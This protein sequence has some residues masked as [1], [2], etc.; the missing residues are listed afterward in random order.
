MSM[1][2]ELGLVGQQPNTALAVFFIPYIVFEI[3]SNIL[4]KK[5]TPHVWLTLCM[6]GFGIVMLGQGFVQNYNG[7]L[8]TRIL[9][10]LFEAGVFPGS[11]YLISFWYKREESQK[12]FAI[13]F[14]SAVLAS[15]FG[16]LLATAIANMDGVGGKSNWRWIFILEGI[17]SCLVAFAAFFLVSDFPSEAKW[18]SER[19]KQFVLKRTH[20]E[21]TTSAGQVNG[22]DIFE[23]F[24]DPKNYLGALMYLSVVEP[25]YAFA[26]FTPTII[27]TLGYSTVQT[28]LHS[29]PP[30]AAALGMC[31]LLGYLSDRSKYRLPYVLFPGALLIAGLAILMTTHGHYSAQYAGLCLV[32][33]G[34]FGGGPTVICWYLMNLRGHQQRS[35]GSAFMISIGNTGGI[36]APFTFLSKDSPYYRTGYSVCM[37]IVVLGIVVSVCYELLV[38]RERRKFRLGGDRADHAHDLSL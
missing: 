19:E 3:P 8:A 26:Y 33:M 13:Y 4:L 1:P 14:C 38:L 17:F 22:R 2:E 20:T 27:K 9:L 5:F 7:L 10:G 24:K 6:L 25:I 37:G 12:R 29:V 18:L 21:A 23:F 30:F 34:A 31:L 28:Q 15:A 16:G 35:I 32:C 11:F 36:I